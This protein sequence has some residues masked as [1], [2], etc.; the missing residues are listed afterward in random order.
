[1]GNYNKGPKASKGDHTRNN[2]NNSTDTNFVIFKA[3]YN[4][5][6]ID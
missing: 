1:M 5:D 2:L 6:I 4:L 3:A